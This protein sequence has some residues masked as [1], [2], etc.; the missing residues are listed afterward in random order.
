MKRIPKLFLLLT[1]LSAW[2]GIIL[3][4]YI[5]LVIPDSSVIFNLSNMVSYFTIQS[6]FMVALFSSYLLIKNSDLNQRQNILNFG[7]LVN[8]AVTALVFH[9]TLSHRINYE[10]LPYTT[11]VIMHYITPCLFVLY[12][13]LFQKK[14]EFSFNYS[15][16]WLIYPIIYLIYTLIRG[17][18]VGWYP[19]PF[20]DASVL[21]PEKII[22]NSIG[23]GLIFII[24]GV[25][26]VFLSKFL[27]KSKLNN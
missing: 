7:I 10:G 21:S 18:L 4:V 14:K 20:I 12:W 23:V 6:N 24:C 11:T 16:I 8:I 3:V 9:F 2:S 19:Y 26:F 5:N 1:T 13:I 25:I 17:V 27:V 22:L 15:L